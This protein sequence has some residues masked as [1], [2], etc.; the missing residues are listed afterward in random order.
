MN[1]ADSQRQATISAPL[2]GNNIHASLP[3]CPT[4]L[5]NTGPQAPSWESRISV[6]PAWFLAATQPNLSLRLC[7]TSGSRCEI[8][9]AV[10]RSPKMLTLVPCNSHG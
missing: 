6:P 2:E 9:S 7:Q 1:W 8:C 3:R 5:P 10:S 4:S